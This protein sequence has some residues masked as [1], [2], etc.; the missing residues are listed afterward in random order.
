MAGKGVR[1]KSVIIDRMRKPDWKQ[2]KRKGDDRKPAIPF[3][4]KCVAP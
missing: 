2:D 3:V 1:G 4:N